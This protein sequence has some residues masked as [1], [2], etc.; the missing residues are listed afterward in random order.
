M[1]DLTEKE[2]KQDFIDWLYWKG[3]PP[4]ED[5]PEYYT[6]HWGMCVWCACVKANQPRKVKESEIENALQNYAEDGIPSFCYDEAAQV[7]H[8]LI[9]GDS[10]NK[11]S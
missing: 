2:M 10:P 5:N 9:Y 6:Y 1:K 7:I 11:Q 4:D 3:D 8:N